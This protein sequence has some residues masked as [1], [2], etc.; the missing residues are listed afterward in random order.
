[1]LRTIKR[2]VSTVLA[3]ATEQ[4]RDFV[5]QRDDIRSAKPP[6]VPLRLEV[7]EDRI[8]PS[9]Y[10]DVWTALAPGNWNVAS[11]WSAGVPTADA[12]V[13]FGV[14]GGP[15][16]DCTMSVP[17]GTTV[18]SLTI[19]SPYRDNT[20][21][22]NTSLTTNGIAMEAGNIAQPNGPSSSITCYGP[23]NWSGGTIGSQTDG[24]SVLTVSNELSSISYSSQK[25]LGDNLTLI[26][27][28]ELTNDTGNQLILSNNANINITGG[29]ALWIYCPESVG[30]TNRAGSNGAIT[31]EGEIKTIGSTGTS[32]LELVPIVNNS[33]SSLTVGDATDTVTLEIQGAN[34][35]N[36]VSVLNNGGTTTIY[37]GSQLLAQKGFTQQAG[38]LMVAGD[39]GAA[40]LNYTTASAAKVIV[41]GGS[42]GFASAGQILQTMENFSMTGGT[43]NL[44]I[45]ATAKTYDQIVSGI[46]NVSIIN[47][48]STIDVNTINIPAGGMPHATWPIFVA[49]A[50]NY[51]GN[52]SVVTIGGTVNWG[53]TGFEDYTKAGNG[54]RIFTLQS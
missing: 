15:N 27:E 7:L 3:I 9:T 26:G 54:M 18:N 5:L 31:N 50:G 25:T 8:V 13:V 2:T 17:G 22:L 38:S 16:A 14:L 44:T 41:N 45:D 24:A 20:L 6:Q 42:I 36:D 4:V 19:Y 43:L 30:I 49:N 53:F 32:N 39:T 23:L 33:G 46:G 51:F 10:E 37:T 12:D 48:A 11:N 28:L 40:N 35:Q 21:T 34:P 29:A 47:D 1:M 52:N